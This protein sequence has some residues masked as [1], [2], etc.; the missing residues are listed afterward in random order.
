MKST[1]VILLL[2]VQ[3]GLLLNKTFIIVHF[4]LHRAEIVEHYCHHQSHEEEENCKGICYLKV[5]LS[6]E[7]TSP[8]KNFPVQSLVQDDIV[9][10]DMLPSFILTPIIFDDKILNTFF[11]NAPVLQNTNLSVWRPPAA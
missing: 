9:F 4:F 7:D 8:D 3:I 5:Q 10:F 2:T 11:V 6:K 1:L